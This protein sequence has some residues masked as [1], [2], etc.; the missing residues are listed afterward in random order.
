MKFGFWMKPGPLFWL[1]TVSYSFLTVSPMVFLFRAMRTSSSFHRA[2][3]R[4]LLAAIALIWVAGTNDLLPILGMTRYPLVGLHFYPLG[5]MAACIYMTIVAYSVLQHRL[6]DVHVALG[7]FMAHAVRFGFLTMCSLCLLLVMNI[8]WGDHFNVISFTGALMVQIASAILA[9]LLFPRLFGAGSDTLERKI[10][11]DRLEYRDQVRNFVQAMTW[12]ADFPT[13]FGELHTLL[14]KTFR[15][16]SYSVLLRDV[17]GS[18]ELYRTHPEDL[19]HQ[20]PDLEGNSPVA[21]YFDHHEGVCLTRV[22]LRTGGSALEE[23]ARAALEQYQAALCFVLRSQDEPVGFLFIGPKASQEPFTV[24]DIKLFS[25]LVKTLGFV[26]NQIRLKTQLIQSQEFELLGRMSSGMAH[27]L[28]NLLTPLSTLLQLAG[29]TGVL[30]DELLPVAE[31]NVAAIRAYIREGL[32]FSEH[33]RLD[34]AVGQ[35][36]ALVRRAIEVACSA[37]VS[38]VTVATRMPDDLWAEMDSVMVQRLIANLITNAIDAS[39]EGGEIVVAIE[40]LP[41]ADESRDW[42]R[43]RVI[44]QGEG[45]SQ[46]DLD[47]VFTPYFTTKNRGDTHRGFGLGLAICRKIAALHGGNLS[48]ESTIHRGTT[49]IFDLPSKQLFPTPQPRVNFRAA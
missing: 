41:R 39:P 35:L 46:E 33:Q 38:S 19:A 26:V 1:Y 21:R 13:L 12:Y 29:E 8:F 37:R 32:F 20:V 42:L 40:P 43:I 9:T 3:V 27:D 31:R 17:T 18:F 34:F 24:T 4:A 2:R 25:S 49:V 14:E 5:S 11:G 6:L 47:R 16:Q 48:I 36:D 23:G 44:D 30:D 28:N 10:L 7:R 22:A 15:L 45:I